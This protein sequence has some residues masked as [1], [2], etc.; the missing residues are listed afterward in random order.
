MYSPVGSKK[1][2]MTCSGCQSTGAEMRKYF[3]ADGQD[4]CAQAGQRLTVVDLL[5]GQ[6]GFRRQ[7]LL[8]ILVEK[9]SFR[10]HGARLR[11]RHS[12]MAV[13]IHGDEMG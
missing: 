7:A 1:R 2:L 13:G 3:T 10:R 5:E 4:G 8:G 11:R 6:H 9:E 12:S